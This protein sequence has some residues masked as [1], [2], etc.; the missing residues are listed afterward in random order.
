VH[1]CNKCFSLVI[2]ENGSCIRCSDS[3]AA[4]Q[5]RQVSVPVSKKQPGQ[6]KDVK[7]FDVS[8]K[9]TIVKKRKARREPAKKPPNGG[10]ARWTVPLLGIALLGFSLTAIPEGDGEMLL[11]SARASMPDGD[12]LLRQRKAEVAEAT[13]ALSAMQ[14][15]LENAFL[16]GTD[17]GAKTFKSDAWRGQLDGLKGR[18]HIWGTVDRQHPDTQSENALHNALLQLYSMEH[19]YTNASGTGD[20]QEVVSL[21]DS[22]QGYVQNANRP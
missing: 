18:Y 1:H 20:W 13:R 9:R 2:A 12:L 11:P 5:P 17:P 21:R 22:F 8:A 14:V 3:E 7:M 16:D 19:A 10:M 4:E 6:S 15:E